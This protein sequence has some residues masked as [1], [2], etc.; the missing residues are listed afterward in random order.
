MSAKNPHLRP[1]VLEFIPTFAHSEPFRGPC[2]V[3]DISSQH[4]FDSAEEQQTNAAQTKE[5]TN[6]LL[7]EITKFLM[8][9]DLLLH[10][11]SAFNDKT[12]A[13]LTWKA[14]FSS[15]VDGLNV[16]SQEEIDLLVK[17][18]GAE[19]RSHAESVRFSVR[20]ANASDYQRALS[21]IWKRLDERY[22]SPELVELHCGRNSL[23]SRS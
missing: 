21:K 2:H 22:G 15:V 1:D 20:I 11:L 4:R 12:E 19:S 18:L 16:T 17:Y 23:A 14:T 7:P 6:S 9:K 3:D 10:R 8:K 13:Y 5:S